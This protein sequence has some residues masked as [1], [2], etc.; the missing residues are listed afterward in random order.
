MLEVIKNRR[1]IRKYKNAPVSREQISEILHAG[2]L[3]PSSKNRQPWRFIVAAGAAKEEV[4]NV[5]EKGI[6]REKI[7]PFIPDSRPYITGAEHTLQIMRQAPV[8]IFIV[9]EI[10][11]SFDTVS[12]THL[13]LPTICSV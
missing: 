5:M 1:S 4:C 11:A 2:M 7:S 3:A 12:Y 13:T 6:S 8:I 9:N 10:A